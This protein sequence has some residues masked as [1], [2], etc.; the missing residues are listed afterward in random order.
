[1]PSGPLWD[2]TIEENLVGSDSSL[3]SPDIVDVLREVDV[4]EQ[5]QRLPEGLGTYASAAQ[6]SLS[7]EATY[8]IGIARALLHRPPI[9]LVGEPPAPSAH[10]A[11]DPCLAAIQKLVGQGSLVVMLPKRLQTLRSADRVILLNGPNL[12][13]EGKHS[14]LLTDSDLY[15]HLNYLLFNPYRTVK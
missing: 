11:D 1:E 8:A 4:Y 14:E 5:I 9:L 12:A 13:G 7:V 2:G 3:S 10:L 15:R 6:N